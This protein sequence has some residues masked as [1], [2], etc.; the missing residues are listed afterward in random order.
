M[1]VVHSVVM[2][3]ANFGSEGKE[4]KKATTPA[5]LE[6][7]LPKG[8]RFLIYRRNHLAMVSDKIAFE[9]YLMYINHCS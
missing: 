1:G 9:I 6:P 5:G 3:K 2:V 4:A 7:A 8:N